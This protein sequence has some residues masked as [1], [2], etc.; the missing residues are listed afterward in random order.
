[1]E[2]GY[3]M[4]KKKG[5]RIGKVGRGRGE[6]GK[7]P[8]KGRVLLVVIVGNRSDRGGKNSFQAKI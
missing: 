6:A 1:M 8:K 5:E 4:V 2:R 7:F 3:K